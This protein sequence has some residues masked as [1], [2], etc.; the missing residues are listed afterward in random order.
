MSYRINDLKES[1]ELYILKCESDYRFDDKIEVHGE[2]KT[3]EWLLNQLQDCESTL[4]AGLSEY[5]DFK[6]GTTYSEAIQLIKSN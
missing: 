6:P 1:F 3:F 5:M 2:I 4:P